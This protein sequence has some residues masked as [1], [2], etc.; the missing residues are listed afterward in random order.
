MLKD[1][2]WSFI[3]TLMIGVGAGISFGL[4]WGSCFSGHPAP[5]G[6]FVVV[7]IMEM[8]GLFILRPPLEWVNLNTSLAGIRV[9]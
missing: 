1:V 2:R 5:P 3:A 9:D 4:V 7:T 8:T 6:T